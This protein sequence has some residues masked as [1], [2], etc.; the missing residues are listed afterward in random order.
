MDPLGDVAI[1]ALTLLMMVTVGHG[2]TAADFRRSATDLRALI[3]ATIGQ[4][5]LLPLITTVII[6]VFH[7]SPF[8]IAGLIVVAACPG[9]SISNFYAFV[10][11]ANVALS[12]TLTAVSCLLSVVTLP[13]LIAA[14]FFF[15][16]ADQPRIEA[17]IGP[18]TIQLLLLVALPIVL[19]MILRRWRPQ[20]TDRRNIVLRRIS[21]TALVAVVVWVVH[22]QWHAVVVSAGELVFVAFLFTGLAMTA[23][24]A[25]A[26]ITGRPTDDRLCYLIE[27]P[28]RNLALAL[29][30]GVT[31]L[32]RPEILAFVT[33]LLLCQAVVMLGLTSVLR[34]KPAAS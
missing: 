19:G 23:G 26:W 9:G 1:P 16:L 29:M 7:P 34:R 5:I 4:L 3:S 31:G 22:R 10:A 13:T 21:L 12:V 8:I 33:V 18:L 20:T 15:W 28:C 30:V 17:P 6:L 2:L 32:R 25:L 27:F 24:Y 14:G 11:G